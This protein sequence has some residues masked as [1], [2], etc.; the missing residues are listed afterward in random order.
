MLCAGL[1][2]CVGVCLQAYHAKCVGI[3]GEAPAEWWC[4]QC[5]S[6]RMRCF[7]CDEFGTSMT[8]PSMRKC[9][10]GCCGRF[11]HIEYA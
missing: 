1:V 9:S 11:Y 3:Q 4:E 6:G 10:L 8:D 2:K 5:A 7:V